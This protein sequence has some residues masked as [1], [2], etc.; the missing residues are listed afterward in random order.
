MLN[1]HKKNKRS[2][3]VVDEKSGFTWIESLIALIKIIS[4]HI[5]VNENMCFFNEKLKSERT[6]SFEKIIYSDGHVNYQRQVTI[7]FI[8]FYKT[9]QQIYLKK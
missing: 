1:E 3:V 9:F 7:Q 8:F 6:I 5:M 2:D 4:S